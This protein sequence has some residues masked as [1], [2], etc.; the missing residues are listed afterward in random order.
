MWQHVLCAISSL[1]LV[2]P[3]PLLINEVRHDASCAHSYHTRI[4]GQQVVAD[5]VDPAWKDDWIE[6]YAVQEVRSALSARCRCRPSWQSLVVPCSRNGRCACRTSRCKTK[7]SCP[8]RFP[9]SLSRSASPLVA[10]GESSQR[11]ARQASAWWCPEAAR[12]RPFS[13]HSMCQRPCS[14]QRRVH[15]AA[16]GRQAVAIQAEQGRRLGACNIAQQ[17]RTTWRART[18]FHGRGR[19]GRCGDAHLG[20]VPTGACNAAHYGL[21][22]IMLHHIPC[23]TLLAMP[24]AQVSLVYAANLTLVDAITFASPNVVDGFR[25]TP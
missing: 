7:V 14:A 11:V 21:P 8:S 3:Q 20:V 2:A 15:G 19:L 22:A 12:V 10:A 9:T 17:H 23:G 5:S 24:H 4:P 6:L 25:V 16:R 18:V 13:F 1:A